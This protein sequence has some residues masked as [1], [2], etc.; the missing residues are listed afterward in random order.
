MSKKSTKALASA[1][2]MSLVLTTALSAGP[3][4]AAQ[5]KV[6]RTSGSDRYATA[7]SVATANWTTSDD[8]VLVSG[9]G[10]ADA[11]SASAL[12]KKLNAP[13]LLT[14][15]GSL[16]TDTQNALTTLK[17]KN[18]YVV[19][20]NASVSSSVR[21]DLKKNYNLIELGGAN[22]Y[23]TNAAVAQ[24]L[25]DLGVKADEVIM[26][27]GEGFS[28]ALSIAPIAAAK[29]QILLLGVNNS[30][31]MKSVI[32]FVNKNGSK[33]TVVGTENVINSDIYSKVK[34]TNRVNG[35]ADRFDTNMKVLAAYK[36]TVK[37]DKLY[38]ANATG[39][40]YADALVAS[41]V[42]G[43]TGS[44]LVLV[45]T[46]E[47]SATTTAI[48]YIKD[49]AKSTTDLNVIGGTGVV[50]TSVEDKINKIFD[51][52]TN[53]NNTVQSMEAVN[54]NEIKIHFNAPVD[55]D[56]AEDVTNYKIDGVQLTAL[57]NGKAKDSSGAVAK[58]IDDNTV[59]I[60]LA[61]AR[62]QNDSVGVTVKKGSIYTKDKNKVIDESTQTIVFK[63]SE[64]PTIKKISVEGN[65]QLTVEFSEAVNMGTIDTLK[66]KFKI[67]GQSLGNVNTTYSKIKN[68][69]EVPDGIN[70]TP[71]TWAYKVMFYF[72]SSLKEGS[73][74]L[75]VSDG[76]LEGKTTGSKGL[77]C[78]AAGYTFKEAS[79]DFSVDSVSTKPSVKSIKETADGEV[80][81]TFDRPMDV[82]TALEPSNWEI[83]DKNLGSALKLTRD[84]NFD[85]DD[86]DAT[87]KITG[88]GKN[89][90]SGANTMYIKNSIK[91]AYGNKV[92]D[93]T[94]VSFDDLKDDTKPT[95]LN[96]YVVDDQTISVRFSKNVDHNFAKDPSNYKL[97]DNKNV[98]ISSHI[99]KVVSYKGDDDNSDTDTY[100]IKILR[101]DPSDTNKDWRLSGKYTLTIKNIIDTA[102]TSHRM[103]DWSH[104]LTA[105]TNVAPDPTGMYAKLR[106]KNNASKDQVVIYFSQ[107]MD[108]TSIQDKS[109]Y[110]FINGKGETK[111]LP[112]DAS[113]TLGG[114]G[115]SAIVEF[116]SA[117]YV[118]TTGKANPTNKD[119]D[120]LSVIVSN[121]KSDSGV[122]LNGVAYNNNYI[123]PEA[124]QGAI[125]KDN[126][127]RVKYDG[128]DLKVEVQF[129]K[130]IDNADASDFTLGGVTPTSI[131]RYGDLVTLTF[132]DA[133][134]ATDEDKAAAATT[135]TYANGLTNTNPTKIDL[136]KAQGQNAKLAIK[137]SGKTTD[138]TGA[139]VS[140]KL[141]GTTPADLTAAQ[142]KVYTYEAGPKTT[143][144]NSSDDYPQYWTAVKNN[145]GSA[146]VYITFDTPLDLNSGIKT[147]D[148]IFS[149]NGTDLKADTVDVKGNTVVFNF[150]A[151]NKNISKFTGEL[152]LSI[153]SSIQVRTQ[154][155]VDGNCANY[156]PTS[157]D[158]DTR[159]VKVTGVDAVTVATNAVVKAEASKTQADKDAAL[160]LVNALPAGTTKDT[161]LAR[162][163]AIVVS[164]D[165]DQGAKLSDVNATDLG[166]IILYEVAYG[167]VSSNVA[168]VKFYDANG[169]EV[170]SKA[171]NLADGKFSTTDTAAKLKVFDKDGKQIA[172]ATI[173]NG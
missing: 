37:M 104:E 100:K 66:N 49:N 155:D 114:D 85:T 9:E 95:V 138:E 65:S 137:A 24:K 44:P 6:T 69:I 21:S 68:S 94:R 16:S 158:T 92:A 34:G 147:D 135:I 30:D 59:T 87:I 35:G 150:D 127:L 45:D 27:G 79:E 146:N 38:V 148:I 12:A 50:S 93:D 154:K 75:K 151:T 162:V 78:D 76:D 128:D 116:P 40:G 132:K 61:K 98:D 71:G 18:I 125:V 88:L 42:A 167:S 157:H 73:H 161:L 20:G 123:I 163:N 117:Y 169:T 48:K 2:L 63:D 126:T 160:K 81:V 153:K 58:A 133:T 36:D 33:V 60:V 74:T 72:D 17:A 145:D 168:S 1:T 140:T 89:V 129:D 7:A 118:K 55:S 43:K 112:S 156:T 39:D 143:C 56:S 134:P 23:E 102:S 47:A 19:G 54:L 15:A 13:I 142:A 25:V 166:T 22:R 86:N 107:S 152:S 28:D 131:T 136:V 80:H 84:Y 29:G 111:A 14:T 3:V 105:D 119:Y 120:V 101:N 52:N 99:E 115:K 26:V 4:Q 170:T 106:D 5:G 91:D 57:D 97:L 139:T 103:E 8:V 149:G 96:A 124:K 164:G 90:K 32:D 31:S 113:V 77:L 109:N 171:V 110:Q 51:T 82:Q 10:Y 108:S 46:D 130:A 144:F 53:T 159:K 83:N 41:A 172:Y 64:A 173:I 122:L 141:D 121:V 62:K 67:D 70:G 165:T 11:V